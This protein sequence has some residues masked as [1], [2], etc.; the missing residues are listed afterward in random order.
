M[1]DTRAPFDNFLDWVQTHARTI[2]IVVVLLGILDLGLLGAAFLLTNA[3]PP[4]WPTTPVVTP[5]P[6]P[7]HPMPTQVATSTPTTA[8][9]PTVIEPTW[10]PLPTQEPTAT[11]TIAPTAT[12]TSTPTPVVWPT[13]TPTPVIADWKGEYW[14]N[15]TLSG[16]PVLVRNDTAI[17]FVWGNAAPAEGLSADGFSARWTRALHFDGGLYR[18]RATM[19]DGMR[20]YLDGETIIDALQDGSARERTADVTLSAGIHKLIVIYY[21]RSGTAVA[22]FSWE[23]LAA[24]P[25]WK[26]EYWPN[27]K[28]EGQPTLVRN[29]PSINFNWQ[30]GSPDTTL[31]ANGFSARWTRKATFERGTY[32]F[33]ALVD[34]GVRLWVDDQLLINAWSDHSAQEFTVDHALVKGEHSLKVEYYERIGLAQIKVWWEKIATPTYPDWKGEYWPNRT[35]TG[36]PA[37]VRNDKA[38]D[39]TPGLDFAWGNGGPAWGLPAD[40]FSARW[41]RTAQLDAATYRFHALVDDGVRM[42]VDDR[43]VID[44]WYDHNAH[45]ISTDISLARGMHT[46]KVEYYEQAGQAQIKVWWEKVEP[47]FTD[48]KGEYWPN[49]DLI[50]LPS[51]VRNDQ[52]PGGT[53][54]IDMNWGTGAPAVGLP[55]DNFSVRW[56]RQITFAPGV[57]RFSAQA[58]DAIRVYLGQTLIID[59]WHGYQNRTYQ[60]DL[61]VSGTQSLRIEYAEYVGDARVQF[62]WTRI[63]DIA[64][65]TLT[66]T[67]TSTATMNPSPTTTPTATSTATMTPSPTATPTATATTEPTTTPTFTATVEPTA[68][69]T[70]G[71]G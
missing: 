58:D 34:D 15:P 67:A 44:A 63:G 16:T 69:A 38:A 39:G 62:Q 33:Y 41:T 49:K 35:L 28:L 51:L 70:P 4:I 19:D 43:P 1:R 14:P 68:T 42:W 13:H 26:G 11:P 48:W 60:V 36:E 66:P 10:T 3:P 9:E 5:M 30:Q 8:V 37:L 20:V 46:L 24:Y 59:E 54:G 17:N 45:E 61:P 21:E 18:F 27:L 7:T 23:R 31:P 47:S 55:Q 64:T 40:Q 2:L 32:R 12:A 65:P 25:D 71:G 56:S 6:T 52:D 50:G 57:Y 22:Q 29:D 53:L